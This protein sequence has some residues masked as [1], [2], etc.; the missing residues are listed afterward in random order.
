MLIIAIFHVNIYKAR[1][2]KK[3]INYEIAD[4]LVDF[5]HEIS[6]ACIKVIRDKPAAKEELEGLIGLYDKYFF[7]LKNGGELYYN[8]QTHKVWAVEGKT[9]DIVQNLE[10]TWNDYKLQAEDIYK[11][12][13]FKGSNEISSRTL[14]N[15]VYTY[16]SQ[17]RPLKDDIKNA[18][19]YIESNSTEFFNENKRLASTLKYDADLFIAKY[20]TWINVYITIFII[21]FIIGFFAF[22]SFL[23][24]NIVRLLEFTSEIESGNLN[25]HFNS[26]SKDELGAI[27]NSLVSLIS[28][29]RKV[30][31]FINK[32]GSKDFSA[33][34]K[35][36]GE[37]DDL[38]HSLLNMKETLLKAE[39]EN[40]LRKEEDD[41]R[42]W[43]T[44]G[45]AKFSDL[46]R[47]NNDNLGELSYS[48]ISNL[49]EYVGANQGGV[50][51]LN[52]EDS[53]EKVFELTASFAFDRRKFHKKQVLWGE[54]LIGRSALE[55]K[56][57]Y[58]TEVPE[59]YLEITSGLGNF[60]PASILI[61]PLRFNDIIFGVLELASFTKIEKYK[62]EFVEKV[63]DSIASTIS[64][65]RIN[66]KT[67]QLLKES[68][69]QAERLA[70]QEEEMRQNMEEMQATQ[71]E[72]GM[73]NK[74]LE[75]IINAIDNSF[76]TYELTLDGK[77]YKSNANFKSY[78]EISD[79][80]LHKRTHKEMTFSNFKDMSDYNK[81]WTVISEGNPM[82]K[83]MKYIRG[84][85]EY[86]LHE[87]YSAIF[88]TYGEISRIL[89]ITT[90]IT[91]DKIMEASLKDSMEMF[92]EQEAVMV[93]SY[94]ELEETKE[95][96][97]R[98]DEETQ[99]KLDDAL[100][101]KE[102]LI[103]KLMAKEFEYQSEIEKL[104]K[105]VKENKP[106]IEDLNLQ[107]EGKTTL[108]DWEDK[109][110]VNI[111]EIDSQHKKLLDIINTLYKAFKAGKAKKEVKK[112][113]NDLVGYTSYHFGTEERYFDQFNYPENDVH[114]EEHDK[115][116]A[117]VLEFQKNIDSGKVTLSAEIM[118]FL[119]TWLEEH[120]LHSDKK[121]SDFLYEKLNI[122]KTDPT[123]TTEGGS[124]VLFEWDDTYSI[125]I[126]LID[127]QHK[128]L[129][130]LINQLHTAF[131]QGRAKKQFKTII[132]GLVDYADYH[133]GV[134]EKY[135]E[136][137]GYEHIDSHK[138]FH[139]EFVDKLNTFQQD[140]NS[141]KTEVTYELMQ[142]LK[143]W[144]IEHIVVE[145]KKYS[146]LFKD[147]GIK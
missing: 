11:K 33:Q 52:D 50:F 43:A 124:S 63:S 100:E 14:V 142:Y 79:V 41:I 30:I 56:T 49:I 140:F 29:L 105:L 118:E 19:S 138:E 76:G 10:Q 139:K 145:D 37:D 40:K 88:N 84:E 132:K 2:S 5:S 77:Y 28:N 78:I 108:I 42:N 23:Y 106:H 66:I 120:I 136:E 114:K 87:S 137:F 54:G 82:E 75:G 24:R 9:K 121:Y 12:E 83:D 94:R 13:I 97:V 128:I 59:D 1:Y 45:I 92:K 130:D 7:T 135:F 123:E 144:L 6:L 90:N 48:I 20:N 101:E 36:K 91:I 55:Q 57:L 85:N 99:K 109:F 34:Y 31:T 25:M 86:F 134:E 61:T 143:D 60:K 89:V 74:E 70:Q 46:L 39:E 147:K 112:I 98:K 72:A 110:S 107:T 4:Y 116:T 38:G 64:S 125:D 141:N 113:L 122:Q 104:K 51:I 16:V 119:K 65:V 117:Q 68:K 53:E 81:F 32:V 22:K 115:L 131:K 27:G 26:K 62:I 58:I 71:E 73:R 80:E 95:A 67:S 18:I 3:T 47:L 111:P 103:E 69:E 133:F 129:I 44:Q 126:K 146:G 96:L 93:K 17:Y 127:D 8:D 21:A 35:V 15:G 102:V